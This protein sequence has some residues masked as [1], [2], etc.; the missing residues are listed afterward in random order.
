MLIVKSRRLTVIANIN[1]SI[2]VKNKRNKKMNVEPNVGP[3]IHCILR[4]YNN[5]LVKNQQ[6][7]Q[8]IYIV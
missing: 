1:Y 8:I 4:A 6:I 3:V 5:F 7:K 2:T